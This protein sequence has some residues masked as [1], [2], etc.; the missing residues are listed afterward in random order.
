MRTNQQVQAQVHRKDH[1]GRW[2]SRWIDA[3]FVRTEEHRTVVIIGDREV[4]KQHRDVK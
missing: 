1:S 4:Y 3:T 2:S